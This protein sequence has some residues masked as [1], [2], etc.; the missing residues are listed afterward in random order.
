MRRYLSIILSTLI[1]SDYTVFAQY[2]EKNNESS[3]K[4]LIIDAETGEPLIG[5]NITIENLKI[6]TITDLEGQF[7][8][9]RISSGTQ[10]LKI[11]LIGYLSQEVAVVVDGREQVYRKLELVPSAFEQSEVVVTATRIGRTID[12]VPVRVEM[13]PEEEIQEKISMEPSSVSMVVSELP[14]VRLQVTSGTSGAVNL[15]IQGLSGRY[16]QLLTDGIPIFGGLSSAFGIVQMPPLNLQQVEVV[17]GASSVLYG[18]DAIAGV[19]NFITKVPLENHELTMLINRTSQKGADIASFYSQRFGDIGMTLLATHNLQTMYDIDGDGYSD[20]AEYQRTTIHPKFV[21]IA[22]DKFEASLTTGYTS[23][24]RKGGSM[25]YPNQMIGNVIG[26]REHIDSRRWEGSISAQ[27]RLSSQRTLSSKIA[28]VVLNRNALYGSIPFDATQ[29]LFYTEAQYSFRLEG[30]TI[31]QTVLV[32]G[33]LMM[34]QFTDK[35]SLPSSNRSYSYITPGIFLQDELK[36]SLLW[37]VLVSGRIDIHNSYGTFLTPRLSLMFRPLDNLTFRVG[38]GTGYKAPTI[39]TEE[40]ESGTYKRIYPL[41]NVKA[42]KAQSISLD[43]NY[44]NV[45]EIISISLNSSFFVTRIQDPLEA[46]EDSLSIG[47]IYHRNVAGNILTRGGEMLFR[48]LFS[49]FHCTFSYTYTFAT[50]QTSRYATELPLTP[51]HSIAGVFIWEDDGLGTRIGIENYFFSPQWLE[52]NPFRD[53]SPWYYILGVMA[54][55]KFGALR[56]FANAENILDIRPTRYD[57]LYVQK[58][59]DEASIGPVWE[60]LV[61]PVWSPVEGRVFNVGIKMSI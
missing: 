42:E 35:T 52:R 37:T 6:G 31:P 22:S 45:S 8:L 11:S 40:T 27:Y 59:Q 58:S 30:N 50:K 5:A 25:N 13:I 33:A 26:Y 15:R 10:K 54:E 16:T 18:S 32:G 60:P 20:V 28:G 53:R 49:D 2:Q 3:I 1:I 56:I 41:Q 7:T 4:G 29:S 14:G 39:F 19:V 46:D 51:R 55:K 61:L 47:I 23:E 48:V 44:R 43:V 12:D 57:P 24:K 34:D 17:K 36:L 9:N 38:G 21:L